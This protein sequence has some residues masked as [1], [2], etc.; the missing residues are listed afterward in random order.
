MGLLDTLNVSN[1]GLNVNQTAMDVVGHNIANAQNEDY[2][3]QR[4]EISPATPFHTTPGDIGTG[5]KIAQIVRIHDEF[6]YQR[7]SKSLGKLQYNTFK[8]EVL[9]EAADYFPDMQDSGLFKDLKN[10]FDAWNSLSA[11]P[12]DTAQKT[13]LA[14]NLKVF[15][16]NISESR[17][18]LQ[19][20]QKR[21]NDQ[22]KISIDEVNRIGEKIANINKQIS[23]T[24]VKTGNNANDLRDQRD[25]L[26]KTL[27]KLLDFSVFKGK[28]K[29]DN[30]QKTPLTDSGKDYNLNI[31]GYTLIDG[32]TFHP[33]KIDN[34]KNPNGFYQIS[35]V[36]GDLKET[37]IT[38]KITGGKIGA[39]LDLRGRDIN[40]K[41]NMPDDGLLQ[42][43]L[44]DLDSF[45]KTFIDK[46][47][48]IYAKSAKDSLHSKKMEYYQNEDKAT[49]LGEIKEG[50]FD[51]VVYNS[52]GE[53]V[54]RREITIDKDT[55][56][57]SASDPNSII[58][59]LN[60]DK[61]DNQDNDSTNDFDDL[62]K[63][64]FISNTFTITPKEGVEGYK[65]A[66]E[67]HGT[68]FTAVSQLGGL[69]DGD[70]AKNIALKNEYAQN[71]DKIEAY[72]APVEGNNEVANEMVQLQYDRVDFKIDNTQTTNDTLYGFYSYLTSNMASDAENAK[73]SEDTSTALYNSVYKE[74]QSISGVNID[75]ELT[76]LIKYQTGYTANAKVITTID[77]MLDVLLGIKQ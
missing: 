26:E 59:K 74:F 62:F 40:P 4:V 53:E 77:K 58:A 7:L 35:Y 67:D 33:L 46:T 52:D 6:I 1:S 63:A 16:K 29:S 45:A 54:A 10:Y 51:V 24:E 13:A 49:F 11:H 31:A 30:S 38:S 69:L 5:A 21:V 37:D 44:N 41:T 76:N 2:T 3:R 42:R 43:Y 12:N 34:H 9:Q 14:Q 20:L 61:D 56:M 57:N 23:V 55:K 15:A 48:T 50:S 19:S 27:R 60:E 32:T 36:R 71:P 64:N 70:S 73:R 8:K 66:I 47:N 25:K 72:M 28:L 65:I 22:L 75:E 68:N 17:E 39:I 18:R